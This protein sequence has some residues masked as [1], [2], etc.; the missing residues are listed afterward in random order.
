[1]PRGRR[2][3]FFEFLPAKEEPATKSVPMDGGSSERLEGEQECTVT[4]E[5]GER[6]EGDLT[7]GSRTSQDKIMELEEEV[8]HLRRELE[9]AQA[10]AE[11]ATELDAQPEGKA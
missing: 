11:L 5:E 9:R 1:M 10:R 8:S 6:E 2:R 3:Y 7:S 4:E